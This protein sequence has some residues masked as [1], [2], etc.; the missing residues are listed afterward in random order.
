VN[1]LVV[2]GG[3]VFVND[4]PSRQL[5]RLDPALASGVVV[6]DSASGRGNANWYGELRSPSGLRR[7]RGDSVFFS[8][9]GSVEAV[10][11]APDGKIVRVATM[12]QG[13]G[14]ALLDMDDTGWMTC[15]VAARAPVTPPRPPPS[16]LG[17]RD[18]VVR[19]R[20]NDSAAIAAVSFKTWDVDT[21]A[22]L[23]VPPQERVVTYRDAGM[24]LSTVGWPVSLADVWTVFRDGTLAIARATDYHIDIVDIRG[25]VTP[26][27]RA[28]FA[29]RRLTDADKDVILDSL[30]RGDSV[31]VARQDSINSARAAAG[32]PTPALLAALRGPQRASPDE[33]PS[34]WPPFVAVQSAT[35]P[36]IITDEDG[37][38]WVRELLP[39]GA[40]SVSVY[41]IFDRKGEFVDRIKVPTAY[42]VVGFGPG[43]SV[44]MTTVEGGRT[45]VLR[46]QFSAR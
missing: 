1:R 10:V 9:S 31:S 30:K 45:T 22:R 42:R 39:P 7:F 46:A 35:V 27:P 37:R 33:W 26:G 44:Y 43:G 13:V 28:P 40:D 18:S 15:Q 29:W 20:G 5:W 8:R 24:S 14:C 2:A 3:A 4:A 32:T 36:A 16:A 19:I 17:G 11:I 23:L 41:G 34:F 25:N 38:V 21:I 6:L 12:P